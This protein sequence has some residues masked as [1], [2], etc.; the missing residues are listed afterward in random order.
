MANT[1]FNIR[2]KVDDGRAKVQIDGLT[3]GFVDAGTAVAKLRAEIERNGKAMEGTAK[4]YR[5]QISLLKEQRDMSAKTA[6]DYARQTKAIEQVQRKYRSLAAEVSEF[7][8]VNQ[9]QISNAGLAGATLTELGRTISDLPYGMRGV[10]NN[11]SQLATLFFTLSGKT[12]GFV[13][14][15]KLLKAQLSGPL[16]IIL[17]FQALISLLDF[18]IAR[19]DKAKD[20]TDDL[21]DSMNEE[22]IVLRELN[23]AIEQNVIERGKA[24]DVAKG[25]LKTDKELKKILEDTTLSEEERGEKIVE[26]LKKR[27]EEL[28][29]EE[30]I[31]ALRKE[32]AE[33]EVGINEAIEEREVR[34]RNLGEGVRE[35]NGIQYNTLEDLRKFTDESNIP[36]EG[37]AVAN[38]KVIGLQ[39]EQ[40]K[41]IGE[42]VDLMS[43][44]NAIT[45]EGV[46]S[47]NKRSRVKPLDISTKDIK[48]YKEMVIGMTEDQLMAVAA[49]AEQGKIGADAFAKFV[50]AFLAEQK[51]ISDEAQRTFEREV[52]RNKQLLAIYESFKQATDTLFEAEISREE[53]RTVLK[54]NELRKQLKN[55]QLTAQQREAINSQ[56]AT[57][58][59]NLDRKRDKIAERQFKIQK[60][61][62]IGEALVTTYKMANSA[63]EAVLVSPLKFLGI[64]ALV[65]AKIAAGIATAFGLANVAAIARQQFVPSAIGG[66][67]GGGAGGVGG[68]VQAPD[69]NI[70]GAS[71]QSQLAETVAT[72]ES[73]PVR[74][75]VVGKDVSTQQELDRNITNTASFG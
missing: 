51:R 3:E 5:Q 38:N 21:T 65:Q 24:L 54:N 10:A 62:M 75:Y 28:V 19:K 29:L 6:E 60:A 41:R 53:R 32:I 35:V 74:A 18:L 42:L 63:F 39:G 47:T 68:G 45:E 50:T 9:D 52:E 31:K 25:L 14:S 16:G 2:I 4:W 46:E 8:K 20:S 1:N 15:L 66:T 13:S 30:K 12:G 71:A 49:L 36:L 67:G 57:N 64:G 44:L 73:H 34:V 43:Q 59:E 48:I 7:T 58:E 22:L 11:L 26:L 72:A 27:E 56:I 61:L 40:A 55:E 23:G 37:L 69:F 33:A 70:V 17:A